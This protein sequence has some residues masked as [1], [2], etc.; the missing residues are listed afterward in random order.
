MILDTKSE[1]VPDAPRRAA[2]RDRDPSSQAPVL[3]V[4]RRAGRFDKNARHHREA[5]VHA[6]RVGDAGD[7]RPKR[8]AGGR[9]QGGRSRRARRASTRARSRG[10]RTRA[11]RRPT[12]C[13]AQGQRAQ[14]T[15]S[16]A[17]AKRQLSVALVLRGAFPSYF[18]GKAD[19]RRREEGARE[20]GRRERGVEAREP[21]ARRPPRPLEGDDAS[22]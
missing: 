3:R 7:S 5:G 17:E 18:A 16:P 8:R 11:R 2:R 20:Q 12:S 19:A 4:H 1:I 13:A 22:S 21:R 10:P 14:S 6:P 9:R 15:T